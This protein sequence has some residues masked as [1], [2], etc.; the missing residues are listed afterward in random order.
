MAPLRDIGVRARIIDAVDADEVARA[1][2]AAQRAGGECGGGGERS[3]GSGG[4]G[5][6]GG[7][8]SCDAC[9]T[10]NM[11]DGEG[12]AYQQDVLDIGGESCGSGP[13]GNGDGAGLSK[14][15]D[16][17]AH[18]CGVAV[19]DACGVAVSELSGFV[20][21]RLD[22]RGLEALRMRWVTKC[23][24][25]SDIMGRERAGQAFGGERGVSDDRKPW[26]PHGCNDGQRWRALL[27]MIERA[28]CLDASCSA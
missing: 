28:F 16:K 21:W 12:G 22:A 2:L 13:R 18:A 27:S 7:G 24:A 19:A 5:A 26:Q 1:Q 3:G 10:G 23:W 6:N 25:Q 14:H 15:D 4:N 11:D 17:S 8:S 20:S 9:H